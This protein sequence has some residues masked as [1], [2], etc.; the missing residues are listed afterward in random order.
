VR[1]R[2]FGRLNLSRGI[3][4]SAYKNPLDRSKY[5]VV[6]TPELKTAHLERGDQIVLASDGLWDVLSNED[7]ARLVKG[8]P[9]V[10]A[11]KVLVEEAV[12]RESGDNIT[13]LVVSADE[14]VF[15]K[16]KM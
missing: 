4:D 16:A 13:A 5:W 12:R 14:L 9:A 15:K 1:D 10:E 6:S 7:V 11:A 2:I 3:G 8:L